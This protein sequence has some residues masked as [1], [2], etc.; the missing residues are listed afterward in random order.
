MHPWR[1]TISRLAGWALPVLLILALSACKSPRRTEP[2]VGSVSRAETGLLAHGRK[3]F[4]RHCHSCHPDGDGGL[5][6]SLNDKPLPGGLIAFQVRH[7]LGV[8]PAFD[9]EHLSKDHLKA[10]IAY[11]KDLR[12]R[13]PAFR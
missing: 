2:V 6:P 12:K 1:K 8:M 4:D 13:E 10:I 7:G 11:M 5:G 9:E 3:A